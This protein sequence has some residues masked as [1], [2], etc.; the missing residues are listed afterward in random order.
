MRQNELVKLTFPADNKYLSMIGGM[1]QE[2]ASLMPGLPD[3]SSYNIELAVNEAVVNIITHA[4]QDD[5]FGQVMLTFEA[6][7]DRL[8]IRICDRGLSFDASLIPEPDLAAPH[9]SGYGVYLI[10][11]LMDEVSYEPDTPEGNCVT[12]VKRIPQH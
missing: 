5:P 1:V 2:I 3:A 9:E 6:C 11:Q 7:H 8:I 4:Y 12:L 10:R